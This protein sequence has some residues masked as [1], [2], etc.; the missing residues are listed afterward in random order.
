[1]EAVHG[2]LHAYQ[3]LGGSRPF[4]GF[5]GLS[6]CLEDSLLEDLVLDFDRAAVVLRV[7]F[8]AP[9]FLGMLDAAYLLLLKIVVHVTS[10]QRC[11]LGHRDHS[12]I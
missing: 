1:M 10:S 3:A 9:D 7:A 8:V 4:G 2:L 5:G 6:R 12:G 11:T